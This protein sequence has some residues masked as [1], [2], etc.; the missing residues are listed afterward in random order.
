M[1]CCQKTQNGGPWGYQCWEKLNRFLKTNILGHF[2]I[3]IAENAWKWPIFDTPYLCNRLELG[4]K[5][6]HF[7]KKMSRATTYA[8]T[9]KIWDFDLDPPPPVPLNK[10]GNPRKCS[11]SNTWCIISQILSLQ[12]YT[13]TS[14][15][16]K[17]DSSC[18]P[19]I[20]YP[21]FWLRVKLC[22]SQKPVTLRIWFFIHNERW[23]IILTREYKS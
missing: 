8:K 9:K 13:T 18:N 23:N 6:A 2:S 20:S 17:D 4:G 3:Q 22:L 14:Y 10:L 12:L 11:L 21:Q 19:R 5:W 15:W 1:K 7:E 16:D